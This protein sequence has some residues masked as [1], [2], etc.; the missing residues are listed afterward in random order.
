MVKIDEILID[1]DGKEV[2]WLELPANRKRSLPLD[3][4]IPSS[5]YPAAGFLNFAKELLNEGPL[6]GALR[7]TLGDGLKGSPRLREFSQLAWNSVVQTQKVF[8]HFAEYAGVARDFDGHL[9]YCLENHVMLE[10]YAHRAKENRGDRV[11]IKFFSTGWDNN[12]KEFKEPRIER[13]DDL[14]H[15]LCAHRIRRIISNNAYYPELCLKLYSVLILPV[16]HFLGFEFSSV[17]FD[18]PDYM[19]YLNKKAY[20]DE[21]SRRYGMYPHFQEHW[22]E[23]Y[24]LKNQR[25]ISGDFVESAENQMRPLED[26]YEVVVATNSRIQDVLSALPQILWA[27]EKCDPNDQVTDFQ[28]WYYTRRRFI[29]EAPSLTLQQREHMNTSFWRFYLHVISFL[30]FEAIET[31][32]THRKILLFG[33]SGWGELF[34]QYFQNKFLTEA[35]YQKMSASRRY[36]WIQVNANYSYLENNPVVQRA[37]R[38]GSP[39]LGY[40]AL[41]HA[42]DWEGFQKLEYRNP[43]ELTRKIEEANEIFKHPEFLA[44]QSHHLG[45]LKTS[46]DET[47]ND[48]LLPSGETAQTPNSFLAASREHQDLF[49]KKY[50]EYLPQHRDEMIEDLKS[51]FFRKQPDFQISQSRF[52]NRSYFRKLTNR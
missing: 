23:V 17:D 24:G 7:L 40:P 46:V 8:Q 34:P 32:Q 10:S 52:R 18:V 48:M 38:I 50:R 3:D 44:S 5:Y 13:F 4:S 14:I 33:D 36:L 20:S 11:F 31:L 19:G 49:M 25:F 27:L 2:S 28:L 29:Q 43:K 42:K 45:L 26:S 35:E 15:F 22:N 39:F 30:K 47:L 9:F 21:R 6:E 41:V 16:F 12:L 51:L 1:Y 37:L